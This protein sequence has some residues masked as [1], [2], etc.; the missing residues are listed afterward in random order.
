MGKK[1]KVGQWRH[2]V[3][4]YCPWV[5]VLPGSL[6]G[7]Q[8]WQ[9]KCGALGVFWSRIDVP[10]CSFWDRPIRAPD[11][12][13]LQLPGAFPSTVTFLGLAF[14]VTHLAF[15]HVVPGDI[16]LECDF[17][18]FSVAWPLMHLS[19]QRRSRAMSYW[20]LAE[21]VEGWMAE[22]WENEKC[23]SRVRYYYYFYSFCLL[24]SQHVKHGHMLKKYVFI[25]DYI[26][27]VTET[28][29]KLKYCNRR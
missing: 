17:I 12:L 23:F 16:Y 20:I 1:L 24:M 2:F 15:C 27:Y 21:S 4:H 19:P 26:F 8:Y 29:N 28:A 10:F 5:F 25:F 11:H 18:L 3:S 13:P 7:S 14:W 6:A 22:P 9:S